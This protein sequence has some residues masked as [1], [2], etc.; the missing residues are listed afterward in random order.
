[1]IG[2]APFSEGYREAPYW[3]DAF[4]PRGYPIDD[5]PREPG[6]AIIGAGYTGL[7]AALEFARLGIPCCVLDRADPG[8]CASTRSGGIV[9]GPG[10]LKTPLLNEPPDASRH[11]DWI[12]AAKAALSLLESRIEES[13]MDCQWQSSGHLRL[14]NT[15]AQLNKLRDRRHMLMQCGLTRTELHS[16]EELF[17]VLGS[18]FYRG[19]MATF[20]GGHLHPGLYFKALLSLVEKQQSA[21]IAAHAEVSD[22]KRLQ[23]GWRIVTSRGNL[24]AQHILVATNGYT[25]DLVPELQRRVVPIKAY[26]IATKAILIGLISRANASSTTSVAMI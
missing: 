16:G 21:A 12:R 17:G 23:G 24:Q 5:L 22:V 10:G 18:R 6:V 9:G 11:S 14:A 3:W 7:S 13:G 4:D 19:G 1:M 25:G 8:F 26:I 20:P 2:R 15:H